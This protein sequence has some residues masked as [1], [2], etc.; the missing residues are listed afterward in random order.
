MND[1]SADSVPTSPHITTLG[2]TGLE[3]SFQAVGDAMNQIAQQQQIDNAQLNQSLQWQQQERNQ[4]VVVMGRVAN[5]TLQSSYDSIFA[6]IPIYDVSDTKEFWSWLHCIES[7][8]SYT[9]RNPCLEAMGKRT[10]KVLNTFMSILQ[11]V[12]LVNSVT[13]VSERIL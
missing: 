11:K 3:T 7:A 13:H 12:S 6:L 8:C 1:I 5:A 10:G 4:M 2:T 9:N